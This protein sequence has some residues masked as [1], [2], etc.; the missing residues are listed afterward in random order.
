VQVFVDESLIDEPADRSLDDTRNIIHLELWIEMPSRLHQYE[1]VH[2]AE[3]LTARDSQ[4]DLGLETTVQDVS[5]DD[6]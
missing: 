4:P 5:F 3:P 1:G 2:F 6:P